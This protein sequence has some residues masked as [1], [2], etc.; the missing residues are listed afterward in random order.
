MIALTMC[1]ETVLQ[2]SNDSCNL[3]NTF[4]VLDAILIGFEFINSVN[5]DLLMRK[6]RP[7]EFLS[8]VTSFVQ[9]HPNSNKEYSDLNVSDLASESALDLF[10]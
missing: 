6:R 10:F 4:I 1:C 9:S 5:P 3:M 7:Y 8:K 2:Q